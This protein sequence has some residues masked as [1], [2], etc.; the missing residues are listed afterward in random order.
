MG[1]TAWTLILLVASLL[2]DGALARVCD[3]SSG[4]GMVIVSS[5]SCKTFYAHHLGEFEC[6]HQY[7]VKIALTFASRDQQAAF[8]KIVSRNLS[9]TTFT[10]APELVLPE[11]AQGKL[12]SFVS[13]V[14]DGF[15]GG[16]AL[17]PAVACLN[18]LVALFRDA[19][20]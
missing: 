17:L 5:P 10:M 14:Y 19:T 16:N 8:C 12:S 6:P 4:H 7:D 1:S 20:G 2:V 11:L 18:A 13:D 3:Y 9:H 15:F